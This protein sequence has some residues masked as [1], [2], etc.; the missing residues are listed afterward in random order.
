MKNSR[1]FAAV[2]AKPVVV[3]FRLRKAREGSEK[4]GKGAMTEG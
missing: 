1:V 2:Q 3:G 4:T